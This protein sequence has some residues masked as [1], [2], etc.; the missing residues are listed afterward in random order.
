MQSARLW[1]GGQLVAG[2]LVAVAAFVLLRWVLIQGIFETAIEEQEV[3][4][5]SG[6]WPEEFAS[7]ITLLGAGIVIG[8]LTWW[9][10]TWMNGR[11][12][13]AALRAGTVPAHRRILM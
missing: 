11:R 13:R 8:M 2:W 6:L 12:E 7:L 1:H 4:R 10:G 3:R 5:I 9:T